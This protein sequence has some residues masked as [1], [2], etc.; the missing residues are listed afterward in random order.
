M[1]G[2]GLQFQACV[3]SATFAMGMLFFVAQAALADGTGFFT[4]AQ[5]N[6]GRFGQ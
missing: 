5:L 4:S 1:S 3:R 6:Q 2:N